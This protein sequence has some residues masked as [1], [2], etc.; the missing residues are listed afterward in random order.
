MSAGLA[1]GYGLFALIAGRF[2]YPA[3]RQRRQWTFVAEADRLR[4][5]ESM[6]FRGPSG[7]T[8]SVTRQGGAGS[9]ADFIALSSTCP[10]L[11]CQVHWEAH[12][13]RFFCPCHNGQFDAAGVGVAGPPGEA[14]MSLPRYP[15][16]IDAGLLYIEVPVETL[17][18]N[19]ASGEVIEKVAGIHG[20]GHDPCLAARP[21]GKNVTT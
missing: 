17:S 14:G 15:L 4:E 7:E 8:V 18:A 21:R 5:G 10:H 6:L 1:A 3:R 11:G 16:R 13:N 2:L 19:R 20:P 9:E 12:N